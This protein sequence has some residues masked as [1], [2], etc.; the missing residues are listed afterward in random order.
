MS[1]HGYPIIKY[2]LLLSLSF[3]FSACCDNIENIEKKS[4]FYDIPNAK[5]WKHRVNCTE[6]VKRVTKEF[7][8]IEVDLFFIDSTNNFICD[9]GEPC[10][11]I[12]LTELLNSIENPSE[13]YY[14]FDFKNP[15]NPKRIK[16]SVKVLDSIVAI[17]NI[18]NKCIIES[19]M[20]ICLN[21]F[22]EN[23][24]YTSYWVQNF[25][26]YSDSLVSLK[27][28][29]IDSICEMIE[30]TVLSAS[31]WIVPFLKKYYSDKNIHIWT[32]S[33]ISEDD[34]NKIKVFN[35]YHF[36][37]VILVDYEKNFIK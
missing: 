16:A 13:K 10:S 15:N 35:D 7:P 22:K 19:K 37:K 26:I 28:I 4:P 11:K 1:N 14:W 31:F 9:H 29:E 23:N 24:F 36:I 30:P 21:A 2:L 33:L 12:P 3:F 8:G 5:L 34:K 27:I 17:F 32:N 18:K 25:D 6:D 20:P